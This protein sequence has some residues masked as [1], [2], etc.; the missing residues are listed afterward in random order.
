MKFK[1]FPLGRSGRVSYGLLYDTHEESITDTVMYQYGGSQ[2]SNIPV[3]FPQSSAHT[4]K[5][6]PAS[7][8]YPPTSKPCAQPPAK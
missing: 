6:G 1:V 5:E 2:K 3:S 8:L 7:K 4:K